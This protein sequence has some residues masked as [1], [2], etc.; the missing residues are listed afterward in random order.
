M[1]YYVIFLYGIFNWSIFAIPKQRKQKLWCFTP[2]WGDAI[3]GI[4]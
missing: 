3:R 4:S 1:K 2:F